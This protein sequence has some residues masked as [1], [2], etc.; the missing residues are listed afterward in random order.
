MKFDRC[1]HFFFQNVELFCL[2]KRCTNR[3]D[4]EEELKD[5]PASL[6]PHEKSHRHVHCPGL[7][8]NFYRSFHSTCRRA[9]NLD[10]RTHNPLWGRTT[11]GTGRIAT[12]RQPLLQIHRQWLL[13]E[14][15]SPILSFRQSHGAFPPNIFPISPRRD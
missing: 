3:H 11:L 13:R 15:S 14:I 8:D 5:V 12:H 4:F 9:Q 6:K 7:F 2:L 10:S 1:T